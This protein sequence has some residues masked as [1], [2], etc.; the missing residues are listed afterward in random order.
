MKYM[1]GM[2]GSITAYLQGPTSTWILSGVRVVA[3][4]LSAYPV[5][6]NI[7]GGRLGPTRCFSLVSPF[8]FP[9]TN[10]IFGDERISAILSVQ[11]RVF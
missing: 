8:V 3:F 4:L 11:V 5:S 2:V 7:D 1:E 6:A 9:F 10:I